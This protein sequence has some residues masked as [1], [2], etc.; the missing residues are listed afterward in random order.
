MV[1]LRTHDHTLQHRR[2]FS[3]AHARLPACLSCRP[4]DI[5]WVFGSSSLFGSNVMVA[6][7]TKAA[8]NPAALLGRALHL[9]LLR[10]APS[11]LQLPLKLLFPYTHY[12]GAP[13][14]SM[15]GLGDM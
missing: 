14:F 7:A 9:P 11:S 13:A 1:R 3:L 8:D 4:S 15:L 6:V 2:S 10:H 12:S 5:F